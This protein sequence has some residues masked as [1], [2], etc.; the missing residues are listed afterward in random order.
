M[1]ALWLT[2]F[3]NRRQPHLN[4]F[5]SIGKEGFVDSFKLSPEVPLHKVFNSGKFNTFV[6]DLPPN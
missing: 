5:V 2:V 6:P 3:W 4:L 1:L